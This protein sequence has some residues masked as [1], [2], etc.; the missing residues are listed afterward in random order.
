L[1]VAN[2]L[3]FDPRNPPPRSN[4][5]G[6]TVMRGPH[7]LPKVQ[8]L[9][10]ENLGDGHFRDITAAAGCVVPEPGYGLGTVILDFDDDHRP[11]IFVANDSTPNFLFHNKGICDPNPSRQR[12]ACFEEIGML[13]GIATN[14]DGTTQASM[15]IGNADVDDN[16]LPDVLTINFSSDTNT[17]HLN[18]KG[19]FFEDRT[20]QYGL[21]L[22]SR[23]FLGWGTGFYDFDGDG[24]EDLFISNGHVFPEAATQNIDSPYEQ[25]PLLFERRGPR[26]ER[27]TDKASGEVM[28]RAMRGR[29]AAFGDIDGDGDIDI[30]L[31]ILNGP[32]TVI[33]NDAPPRDWLIV[34]CNAG[35]KNQRGLGCKVEVMSEGKT[36]RRWIYGGGSFQA[37]SAQYAHFGLGEPRGR[38]VK[39]RVTWPDGAADEFDDIAAGNLVTVERGKPPTVHQLRRVN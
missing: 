17:L 11:D 12:G 22:V 38:R 16:G 1:F 19:P 33:R 31:S 26:F 35:P 32:I 30:I 23:P 27:I 15:G 37:S 24:D 28:Q 2:Y 4:F 7:G 13:S 25:T 36:Q 29:A 9:L 3:A 14:I 8:D 10:Y 34:G 39:L 18:Q 5:K 21:G 6:A 20:A